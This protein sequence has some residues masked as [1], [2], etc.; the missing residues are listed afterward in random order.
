[1]NEDVF[2]QFEFPDESGKQSPHTF[3]EPLH[4]LTSS[5][6]EG[7]QQV[8]QDVDCYLEEGFYVAG[9]VSY[10]AAPAFDPAL[11]V[12]DNPNW[13]LVWFGVFKEPTRSDVPDEAPY[14]A[15][16][17]QLKGDFASYQQGIEQ[18]KEAIE[19]G[20]TYQVNYTTRLETDFKGDD[21]SFYRQLTRN[22]QSSYSAYLR[23]GPR[24]LLSAS[25]ELFFRIDEGRL[26]TKPMKGTAK[27]G[28]TVQEDQEQ[29]EHLLTSE[30]E[31][32]E[33][34]MIV[35]LLR[36]DVGRIAKSGTVRVP[37]LFE[38]ETYPTVHQMTSTVQGELSEEY[39]MYNV[40]RAL[41]PCG[42]IT[43]APK[44]RTM[45]YIRELE[46]S[47]RD[48]YCGAIGFMTPNREAVF[49]VPIRTVMV[50]QEAEEAVYGTGGGVTW[51][52]TSKG[53]YEEILTKA[54]LLTESR[55]VFSLLETLKLEEGVY[56]L[57]DKHLQRVQSSAVY[58]GRACP[59]DDIRDHLEK[60]AR[61]HPTGAY[62]VRLLVEEKG[63]WNI[64]VDEIADPPAK[65]TCKLAKSPVDEQNPF[66]F[67]KTTHRL[68]YEEHYDPDAYTVLLWNTRQQLTEFTIGNLVV[69]MNGHYFTPPVNSGLLAGTFRERLLEEGAIRERVLHLHDL[70]ECEE[71]WFINGVRGWIE[72]ELSW[73]GDLT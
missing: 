25:P 66:L 52:S 55:P 10:E 59:V 71:V 5:T 9:Y 44:V 45:E 61:K 28:R 37:R 67:H 13:P 70:L 73:E 41:F 6:I 24:R 56:P 69:K 50:D 26:T 63:S 11:N 7:V 54:R 39:T 62:K 34:L 31:Q 36:N 16:E 46:D 32:A 22:Q 27:R 49:N 18:I 23:M 65:I 58:F 15:S 51:D 60:L 4:I 8:F 43:G 47:P 30:K 19:R 3:T 14:Q 21:W 1:M 53:E 12:H 2:L 29:I 57:L 72:V 35:D 33:N 38:V 20:D 48:V 40:F 42:S 68:V 17:W 64:S